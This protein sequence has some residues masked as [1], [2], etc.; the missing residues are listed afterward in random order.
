MTS[1]AANGY[2]AIR[3]CGF[4]HIENNGN[5]YQIDVSSNLIYRPV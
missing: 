4:D 1:F 5:S 3:I 2:V